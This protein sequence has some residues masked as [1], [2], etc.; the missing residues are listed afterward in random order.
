MHEIS[1]NEYISRFLAGFLWLDKLGLGA[2]LNLKVII[3]WTLYHA[4]YALIDPQ[5]GPNPDYWLTVLYKRLVSNKVLHVSFKN[6]IYSRSTSKSIIL[7]TI[8]NIFINT[9]LFSL[10][11]TQDIEA[12]RPLFEG[13][14]S[15]CD[16]FWNECFGS[17]SQVLP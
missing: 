16:H 12:V 11:R 6:G 14:S 5:L 4:N 15:P 10:R 17:K 13:Q 2:L 3:R 9:Q 7:G 8:E 1:A